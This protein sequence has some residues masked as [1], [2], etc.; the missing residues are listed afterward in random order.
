M[1][2]LAVVCNVVFFA[3][4]CLVLVT[5][6]VSREAP[7]IALTALMLLVPVAT[8][9]VLVRSRGAVAVERLAAVANLVLL[10]GIVAAM[11]D[12]YPHPDEEG[13][14][15]YAVLAAVTPVLSAVALLR[16]G[17]MRG[18]AAPRTTGAPAR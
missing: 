17:A 18:G 1:R 5:D 3:F 16:R 13:F 9:L 2:V 4:T 7:Y 6:G 10:A 11:V 14:V 12:Q 8:A 15:T